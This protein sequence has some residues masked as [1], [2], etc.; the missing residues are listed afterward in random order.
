MATQL[1]VVNSMEPTTQFNNTSYKQ[2]DPRGSHLSRLGRCSDGHTTS[3]CQL[4]GVNYS[5]YSRRKTTSKEAD[6][7]SAESNDN[8]AVNKFHSEFLIYLE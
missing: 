2:N 6:Y 7:D 3:N 1:L 8:D 4:N 5:K